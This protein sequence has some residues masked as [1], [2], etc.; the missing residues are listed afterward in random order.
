MA[1]VSCVSSHCEL[2][3]GR[4]LTGSVAVAL[5][6]GDGVRGSFITASSLDGVG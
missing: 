3:R 1:F 2:F 4:G 6:G 5:I